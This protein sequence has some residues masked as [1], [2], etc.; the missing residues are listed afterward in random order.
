MSD[1]TVSCLK[2]W[3]IPILAWIVFLFA[4]I[5]QAVQAIAALL[6]ELIYLS[7]AQF[8]AGAKV[9][10]PRAARVGKKHVEE[11]KA[12]GDADFVKAADAVRRMAGR[13]EL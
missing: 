4:V 6:D 5:P 8:I 13:P 3:V 7:G 11:Q 2:A 1:D 9:L 12:H 10:E